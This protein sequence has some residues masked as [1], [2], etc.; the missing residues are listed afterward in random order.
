M[1]YRRQVLVPYATSLNLI[2]VA[3]WI[4]TPQVTTTNISKLFFNSNDKLQEQMHI[5]QTITCALWVENGSFSS[6]A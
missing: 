5:K 6:L 3:F 4:F 2:F 1:Y